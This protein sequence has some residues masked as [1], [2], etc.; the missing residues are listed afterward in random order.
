MGYPGS[1]WISFLGNYGRPI[2]G[3]RPHK[4][5]C[6]IRYPEQIKPKSADFYPQYVVYN[7]PPGQQFVAGSHK[8]LLPPMNSHAI[9]CSSDENETR[10]TK[11]PH[12]DKQDSSRFHTGT[13]LSSDQR[14]GARASRHPPRWRAQ[15]DIPPSGT[16]RRV[17]QWQQI[18]PP[19][20]FQALGAA[21]AG[22]R[23]TQ[24]PNHNGRNI[25]TDQA[26]WHAGS[27]AKATTRWTQRA[28][29]QS[30]PRFVV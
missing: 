1:L 23:D 15:L 3:S 29:C 30:R 9:T 26:R 2:L 21:F 11:R 10:G 28:G 14:S 13:S 18:N 12:A 22:A 24:S 8:K 19:F 25:G 4:M 6:S 7:V 16:R 17:D 27:E 5:L 20:L